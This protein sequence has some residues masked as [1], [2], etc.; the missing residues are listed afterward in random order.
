MSPAGH[1]VQWGTGTQCAT[2]HY[3]PGRCHCNQDSSY[4]AVLS[5]GTVTSFIIIIIII[6]IFVKRHKVV[7]SEALAAVGCVC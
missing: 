7:T 4:S 5:C 3:A 2:I 6:N 1:C